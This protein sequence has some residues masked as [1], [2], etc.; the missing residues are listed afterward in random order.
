LRELR[1][2]EIEIDQSFVLSMGTD[3]ESAKIVHSVIA[4]AKS[5]GL[6]TISEGI[7]DSQTMKK[8]VEGGGEYRQGFYFG[9]AMP[10]DEADELAHRATA[11]LGARSAA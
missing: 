1:F 8:I 5:L 7:E 11:G 2:D 3:L 9:N 4:L 10:A 6:P